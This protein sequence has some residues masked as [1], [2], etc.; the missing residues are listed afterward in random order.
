LREGDKEAFGLQKLL[1]TARYKASTLLRHLQ[2]AGGNPCPYE[3]RIIDKSAS[4]KQRRLRRHNELRTSKKML[5]EM[6]TALRTLTIIPFPGKDAADLSRTLFFFPLVGAFLGL[7]VLALYT[8][9][10]WIGF[11]HLGILAALSVA[12]ITWISGCLHM[13]GLGDVADAFGARK[14][15][16]QTL[17]ILKDPRMG[18]FGVTAIA[19]AL[20]IKVGC[21]QFFLA[22]SKAGII[23]CSLV[24]A[25]SIQGLLIAFVPNAR[26]G[27]VAVAYR[28]K[29]AFGKGMVILSFLAATTI[30]AFAASPSAALAF[31]FSSLVVAAF[32][33]IYCLRKIGGIT[34]DCVGAANELSEISVLVS[35]MMVME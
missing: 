22:H 2:F 13:D 17:E 34:G 5:R 35:A 12:L 24:L 7:I 23:L 11:S 4:Q 27:S 16:E 19:L 14:A 3:G 15:K 31:S 26:A 18:S 29:S 30:A 10:A 21:W 1:L 20:V 6:L 9:A 25:R 28:V 32:F 8:M 33:A